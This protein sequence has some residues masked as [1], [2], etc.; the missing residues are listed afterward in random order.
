MLQETFLFLKTVV[1]PYIL[2]AYAVLSIL[3]FKFPQIIHSKKFKGP[4]FN[5]LQKMKRK[6]VMH[7][8]HRGGSREGLENTIEAFDNA[9]NNAKT[10]MLEFDIYLT[11]DKKIVVFHDLEMSRVMGTGNKKGI[12]EINYAEIPDFLGEFSLHF[13]INYLYRTNDGSNE[14]MRY[15]P[16]LQEIFQRYPDVP[17]TFDIKKY[18]LELILKTE[19]LIKKFKREKISVILAFLFKFSDMGFV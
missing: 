4:L 14:N 15:V 10:D 13:G 8:S 7:I 19:Q 17:M 9:V 3:L 5:N 11:K 2:I 1:S 16:T 18:N 12:D 6:R